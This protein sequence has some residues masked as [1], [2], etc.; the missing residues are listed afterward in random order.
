MDLVIFIIAD[1]DNVVARRANDPSNIVFIVAD[2]D[3][4]VV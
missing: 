2:V 4:F 3:D 1:L